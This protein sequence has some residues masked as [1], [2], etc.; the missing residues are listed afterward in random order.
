MGQRGWEEQQGSK[1]DPEQRYISAVGR[2]DKGNGERKA[3]TV[4]AESPEIGESLGMWD[5]GEGGNARGL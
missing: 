3:R 2:E 5:E 1:Y 4:E